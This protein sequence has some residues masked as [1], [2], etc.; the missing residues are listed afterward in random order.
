MFQDLCLSLFKFITIRKVK[1]FCF[2]FESL[3]IPDHNLNKDLS[4]VFSKSVPSAV[5]L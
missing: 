4:S 5:G 1:Y 3:L 2:F